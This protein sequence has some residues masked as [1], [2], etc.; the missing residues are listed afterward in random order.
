MGEQWR[1]ED[2]KGQ[3]SEEVDGREG[4]TPIR[5]TS[6][7]E[8]RSFPYDVCLAKSRFASQTHE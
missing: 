8:R 3:Q 7:S 1:A 4:S 5:V 6:G 2:L